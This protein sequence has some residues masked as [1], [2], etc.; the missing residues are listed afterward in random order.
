MTAGI[1]NFSRITPDQ[2]LS[3]LSWRQEAISTFRLA[4]PL[5]I[6][7]LAQMALF[8]TDVVMMGWLGPT[9]LAA[10]TLTIMSFHPFLLFGVGILSAVA[11]LAAQAKGS[12]D[13]ASMR[14]SIRQGFWI[15]IAIACLMTPL[16]WNFGSIF[17]LLGQTDEI[18]ALA[19][20]YV[21]PAAWLF[22]PALG[23]IV[24]R[25]LLAT[26]ADTRIILLITLIGIV[27]NAIC[28]YALMFG[29]WGF[30]RL[31]LAGAGL[32]TFIVNLVMFLLLLGYCLAQPVYRDYSLFARFWVPDWHRFGRILLLGTPIGFM[33]MAEVGLFSVAGIFMG[34]LGTDALAGH[35]IALQ[36]A[37]IAFMVPMGLSHAATVR[38]GLA[39][40]RNS[41]DGI[42]KAG[43]VSIG[44]GT[45][46]MAL[47]AMAFWLIPEMLVSFFLDPA[48]PQ[49]Q[50]PFALA[51]TYLGIAAIFQLADGAQ[52]V[53]AAVLRGLNDT[54][55]PMII[56][57]CGY[58]G[59]GTTLG[60]LLAFKFEMG[61]V[62]IWIGL[63]AG[64]AAVAVTLTARFAL[65][66][67]RGH[68]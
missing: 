33:M 48:L 58:W 5:V 17:K 68:A 38:V 25:A 21:K 57:I 19:A 28:N 24:L 11:P 4:W 23:F 62:G 20:S 50:I 54:A 42:M 51:V 22:F 40:G 3:T 27:V 29:H 41:P 10:G 49:N 43:W 59:V 65:R 32:S 52:V 66:I 14:R 9:F 31:E 6:A 30:P 37:A 1:D 15:A 2:P 7:Q 44:I 13:L 36:L 67:R 26:H 64:L 55:I 39:C 56:G 53:S 46:F 35:A 8:T 34:W 61:G 47:T 60:Y 18:S 12:G 45:A 63:A 16:I